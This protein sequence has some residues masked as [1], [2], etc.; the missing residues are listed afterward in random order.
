[1]L[2]TFGGQQQQQQQQSLDAQRANALQAQQAPLQQFQSLLPFVTTAAQTAGTQT[3]AQQF[4]PPPS[5]VQAGLA[6]G[7]GAFGAFGNI[8]NPRN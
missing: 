4:A 7:L 5:P 6:T 3:Q 8:F 1:M 2:S